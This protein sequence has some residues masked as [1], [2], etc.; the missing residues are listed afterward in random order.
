MEQ[1]DQVK[2]IIVSWSPSQV[3]TKWKARRGTVP[4]SGGGRRS[5]DGGS[6]RVARRRRP[7][8]RSASNR[9]RLRRHRRRGRR[10]SRAGAGEATGRRGE[11][12]TAT[13][14]WAPPHRL[15]VD[16]GEPRRLFFELSSIPFAWGGGIGRKEGRTWGCQPGPTV[17]FSDLASLGLWGPWNDQQCGP[18][19]RPHEFWPISPLN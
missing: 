2:A 7:R 16:P 3:R 4:V 11:G 1:T 13:K 8:R 14:P 18:S 12:A 6:D 15:C 10:R 19:P 17:G 5:G 9:R